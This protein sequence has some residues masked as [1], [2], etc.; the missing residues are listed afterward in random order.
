MGL[1][2]EDKLAKQINILR[3]LTRA[4]PDPGKKKRQ[5]KRGGVGGGGEET[6]YCKIF[7]WAGAG[8][9]ML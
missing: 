9:G 1:H 8:S 6:C 3:D 5:Q 7:G 2:I 4:E